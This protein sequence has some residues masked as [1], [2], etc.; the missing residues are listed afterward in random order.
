M[1]K[2][3]I[4]YVETLL[5]QFLP[6]RSITASDP[7]K[8]LSIPSPNMSEFPPSLNIPDEP[9]SQRQG[10]GRGTKW[11]GWM[12]RALVRQVLATDPITCGRGQTATKWKEVAEVLQDLKPQPILRSAESC[13]QRVKKLIEIYKVGRRSIED[14]NNWSSRFRNLQKRIESRTFLTS[15]NR[16]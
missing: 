4:K 6:P 13:R 1:H 7:R 10:K 14:S 12:D 5:K 16:H 2:K 8:T 9:G 15:Q 11:D 3:K